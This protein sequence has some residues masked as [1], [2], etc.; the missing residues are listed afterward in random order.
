MKPVPIH[1]AKAKLSEL[2]KRALAGEPVVIAHGRR[3]M[4]RLVPV[5]SPAG[6]R[7]GAMS[8]RAQVTDAFFEPLPQDELDAWQQ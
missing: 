6:R 5:D 4:V 2:I 3:P 8:G 7:F 1:I